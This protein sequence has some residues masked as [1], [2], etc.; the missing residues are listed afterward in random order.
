MEKSGWKKTGTSVLKNYD[1]Y[2]MLIP[3]VAYYVV[4]H[5]LPM[6]GIQIAFKEFSPSKGIWDS[7][8]V[9]MSHFLRFFRGY[10][11]GRT[12]FNTVTIS[13]YQ[14]GVSFFTPIL[15]ALMLNEVGSSWFK[16]T[17]QTVTYAPY[18]LSTVIVVGMLN[19]VLSPTNGLLNNF[20]RLLGGQPIAFLTEPQWFKTVYVL[21]DV[22][23]NTGWGAI[24]YLAALSS[25]SPELHEAAQIDGAS[26]IQRIIHI[27]LPGILPTITILFIQDNT[28]TYIISISKYL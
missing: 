13:L 9:G 25:I 10:Y 19:V 14:M 15:L 22:W 2:L 16:R 23:Q 26:R 7:P 5:Y 20:I 27:N 21:S 11:A 17:V 4:F 12:I 3:V 1:L 28:A 8:W 24:I 18:F 6:Y